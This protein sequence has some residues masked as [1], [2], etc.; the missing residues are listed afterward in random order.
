ML[1]MMMV[2]LVM[3]SCDKGKENVPPKEASLIVTGHGGVPVKVEKDPSEIKKN[4]TIETLKG[5]RLADYPARNI[6]DAFEGYTYFTSREW[7]E[8]RTPNMKIYVDFYGMRRAKLLSLNSKTNE[9]YSHGINVKFVINPD[10]KFYVAM[11]SK[12]DIMSD[13]KMYVEPIEEK[14]QVLDAIYNNNELN[15]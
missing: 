4:G 5:A 6:G 11:V 13:G 8:T 14:K 15:L 3:M 12:V 1:C 9:T 10:G 7:K 2:C